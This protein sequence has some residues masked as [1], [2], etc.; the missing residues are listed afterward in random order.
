[1]KALFCTV[2]I[3]YNKIPTMRAKHQWD[4]SS[5]FIE[6]AIASARLIQVFSRQ[7]DY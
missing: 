7:S 1:M 4:A 5:S 6:S 2:D 3:K